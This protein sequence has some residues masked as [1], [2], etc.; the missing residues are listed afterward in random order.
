MEVRL[1]IGYVHSDWS[2]LSANQKSS[3]NVTSVITS[4]NVS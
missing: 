4:I 2:L 1:F 3:L